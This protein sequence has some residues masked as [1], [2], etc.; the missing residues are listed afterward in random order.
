MKL[1]K[2]GPGASTMYALFTK[3][4]A[5]MGSRSAFSDIISSFAR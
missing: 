3:G 1:R 5:R 4:V 2:T